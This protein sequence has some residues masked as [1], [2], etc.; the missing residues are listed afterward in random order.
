MTYYFDYFTDKDTKRKKIA[1]LQEL[2]LNG[3]TKNYA[4]EIR[5]LEDELKAS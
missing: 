2:L 4:F 1:R 5:K 3:K